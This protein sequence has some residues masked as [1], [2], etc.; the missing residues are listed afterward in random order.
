M[1]YLDYFSSLNATARKTN[2]YQP[3]QTQEFLVYTWEITYMKLNKVKK[4]LHIFSA[5]GI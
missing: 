3:E 1:E 2:V 5:G 4:V